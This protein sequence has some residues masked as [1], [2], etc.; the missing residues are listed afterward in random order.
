MAEQQITIRLP[1]EQLQRINA[2][3]SKGQSRSP[4]V[5]ELIDQGL[6]AAD[7]RAELNEVRS[8]LDA[9]CAALDNVCATAN[10]T[11][12]EVA[13]IGTTVG[14]IH[15]CLPRSQGQYCT[16]M[17][18][19]R[20]FSLNGEVAGVFSVSGALTPLRDALVLVKSTK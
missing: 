13:D 5:R 6:E 3:T 17:P 12:K 20:R 9:L 4:A 16:L 11:A 7:T 2:Y 15:D 19:C 14:R 10:A 18:A 1:A 8:Q